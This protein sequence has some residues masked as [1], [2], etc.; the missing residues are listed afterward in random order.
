[1]APTTLHEPTETQESIALADWLDARGLVWLHVPSEG[2]RDPG[3]A[4]I[5]RRMGARAGVPDVLILSPAAHAP[6]GCWVEL[7]RRSGGRVSP[8]QSAWHERLLSLGWA[9]GVAYGARDAIALL[10]RLG[11]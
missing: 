10:T 1:M 2:R 3:T 8:A 9:G 6:R 11:Y 5:L 4:A 7:K